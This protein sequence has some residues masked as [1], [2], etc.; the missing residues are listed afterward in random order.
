M[1]TI[2]LIMTRPAGSN[3]AFVARIDPQVRVDLEV[4]ESP[5]IE[6]HPLPVAAPISADEVAIFTSAHGVK[7]APAGQGR[8]AFCIGTHTT[9]V[10]RQKGWAA[11]KAGSDADAL[12]AY[13]VAHPPG[14]RLH[15]LSG[16]HVRGTVTER[17]SAAGLSVAHTAIYDQK[18]IPLTDKAIAL[19]SAETPVLVPLFSPRTASQFAACASKVSALHIVAMSAAV[20]NALPQAWSDKVEIAHVPNAFSMA[21]AVEKRVKRL[22]LA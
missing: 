12:V 10:A 5:L 3:D 21:E 7:F 14:A 4:V 22:R 20:A 16:V 2:A 15:H 13:L 1:A 11:H 18:L 6:I 19:L 8:K 17:L 9:D